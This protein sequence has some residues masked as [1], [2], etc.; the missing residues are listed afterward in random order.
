MSVEYIFYFFR[1]NVFSS[2]YDYVFYPSNN[3]TVIV[4]L[5]DKLVPI[6]K[7]KIYNAY[8]TVI[9]YC[10]ILLKVM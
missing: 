2:S 4:V 5:Q 8:N 6:K 1:I 9:L 10:Q 7:K 3:S